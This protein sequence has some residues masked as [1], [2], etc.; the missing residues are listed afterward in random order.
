MKRKDETPHFIINSKGIKIENKKKIL[1]E[2][3]KYFESLKQTRPP[4]NLHA[5]EIEQ[6][7]NTNFQKIIDD[8]PK[9]KRRK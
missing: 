1:K 9:I 6:E 3:Q 4:E 5:E 8:E 7:R 2:Y